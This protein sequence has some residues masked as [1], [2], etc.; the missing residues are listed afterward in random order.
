MQKNIRKDSSQLTWDKRLISFNFSKKFN[1]NFSMKNEELKYNVYF[2]IEP[3]YYLS[4]FLGLAPFSIRKKKS[5]EREVHFSHSDIILTATL[6][7][8][9]FVGLCF[10]EFITAN[11]AG[12]AVPI[13][14]RALWFISILS[15]YATS[16][17]TL[18]LN[19]TIHRKLFPL[20]LRR[21]CI[22]DSKL[23]NDGTN[24]KLYKSRRS[25]IYKQLA[26]VAFILII[27]SSAYFYN[28]FHSTILYKIN[29]ILRTLCNI[30]FFCISSQY[31][32]LVLMLRARY[33][34]L[35]SIF[36]NL[37][38]TKG[39]LYDTDLTHI[40]HPGPSG[41]CFVLYATTRYFEVCQ[42]RE[43]RN[44]YS[45]LHEVLWLVNKYYGYPILLV[46]I[47]TIV[48]F[49]P[50]FFTGI[51]YIQ[52]AIVYQR[53]FQHYMIM[54]SCLCWCISILFTFA[55]IIS[56][57]HLVTLEVHKLLLYIHKIEIYSNMKQSTIVELRSF[58]SQLRDMKV[59]F[60]ICGLFVLN[61][62]FLCATLG[63]ITTYV[64]VLFQL[65]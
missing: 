1:V 60:S 21:I 35:V 18:I 25:G 43:M 37:L 2:E 33:K 26:I 13:L 29:I 44:I 10:G 42:V 24:E 5:G 38:S 53:E 41:A 50:T 40:G 4:R 32:S 52:N 9:L 31:T 64:T 22:I 27:H 47:S 16:I 34:H 23:F 19:I 51:M 54:A 20:I 63:V 56:S 57:C 17:V 36:S 48:T 59:E 61:L 12:S 3:L 62:P 15:Q 28:F 58:I 14:I 7:I 49:I 6:N 45:Q 65:K 46:I 11:T 55:W 8:L 30:I 39:S